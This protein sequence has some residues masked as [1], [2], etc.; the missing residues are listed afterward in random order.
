MNSPVKTETA[1]KVDSKTASKTSAGKTPDL[2]PKNAE[3]LKKAIAL[4]K[5]MTKQMAKNPDISKATIARAM[6]ALIHEESREVIAQA[7]VEGA[8]LTPKGA[9]TYYYNTKRKAAKNKGA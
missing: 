5:D 6:Y 9:M 7:F 3:Q 4:G 2:T 1:A 8:T